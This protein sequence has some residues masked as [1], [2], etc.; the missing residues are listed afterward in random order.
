[1]H[2]LKIRFSHVAA[3]VKAL[4]KPLTIFDLETTTF[5]GVAAFAITDVCCFTVTLEGNGVIHGHLIDPERTISQDA[6]RLTGITQAMVRGKETWGARYAS[7]FQTLARD[8]WV[9]GFNNKTFDCPAVLE[10]NA[11]YG[12]PIEEGFAHILDVR[13]LY[14]ELEK[15]TSKKGKLLDVASFYGAEPQGALHRAEADVVLTVETLD[16]M[17]EAYGVE[18]ILAYLVPAEEVRAKDAKTTLKPRRPAAVPTEQ[19][20]ALTAPGTIRSIAELAIALAVD[21]KAAS[22]ELGKAVDDQ[23]V[24]PLPFV[25]NETLE[26]LREMLV[27]VP[28]ETLAAGKLKPIFEY[29]SQRQP[30]EI[31]LDYLQLR[32]GMLDCGLNWTSRKQSSTA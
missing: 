10:M 19:L 30:K 25:N 9:G 8:H 22:F 24:D 3:L 5:R 11:R 17:I 6:V 28:T 27:E 4:G 16:L 13:T 18:R 26:W 32:I 12:K 31:P 1:M 20:V 23:L 2:D 29:L 15:P 7:L 14:L 21:E